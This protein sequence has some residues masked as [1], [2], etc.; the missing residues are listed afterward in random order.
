MY[1]MNSEVTRFEIGRPFDIHL[2]V[3]DDEAAAAL[4]LLRQV[5]PE[6][7]GSVENVRKIARDLRKSVARLVVYCAASALVSFFILR[8]E[9]SLGER[10]VFAL[11]MGIPVGLL[12]WL[13]YGMFK[14]N[15]KMAMSA[16]RMPGS[17][18]PGESGPH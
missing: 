8:A 9:K 5:N 13:G 14:R 17:D 12:F 6:R 4:A 15:D 7:F 3:P 1:L 2:Q 18:A 16:D 11:V 10:A